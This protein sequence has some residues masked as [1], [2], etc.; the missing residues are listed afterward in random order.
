[1]GVIKEA[2]KE[3]ALKQVA[4]DGNDMDA[5]MAQCEYSNI[6]CY[7]SAF[8]FKRSGFYGRDRLE[9]MLFILVF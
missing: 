9:I 7:I 4:E 5:D 1:M 3:K 2:D 8:K 6:K